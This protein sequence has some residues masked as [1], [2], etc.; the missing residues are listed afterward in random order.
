MTACKICHHEDAEHGPGGCTTVIS[1]AGAPL[2]Q[3]CPCTDTPAAVRDKA[4]IESMSA[5][6]A[7]AG[8]QLLE[9]RL[10]VTELLMYR[11]RNSATNFQLEKMDDY[12][13]KLRR[14]VERED[15][16]PIK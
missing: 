9:L 5:E 7:L 13:N 1:H 15:A 12:L 2:R 4:M 11:D 6:L 16:N 10:A 14:I 3:V 8:E